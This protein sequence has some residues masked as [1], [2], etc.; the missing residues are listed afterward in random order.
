[1]QCFRFDPAIAAALTKKFP[2]QCT[3]I[4]ARQVTLALFSDLVVDDEKAAMAA[5]IVATEKPPFEPVPCPKPDLNGTRLRDYVG[6]QSWHLFRLIDL[7]HEWL[8]TDPSTWNTHPQ[9][10]AIKAVVRGIPGVND[11]S[12]RDCRLAEDFKVRIS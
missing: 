10:V 8:S 1:M 5:R 4:E 12:E 3:A 6:P 11:M 7:G 2:L 9:Y